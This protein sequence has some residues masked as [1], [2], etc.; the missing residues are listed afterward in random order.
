MAGL[1]TVFT[2]SPWCANRFAVFIDDIAP[3]TST[4]PPSSGW[5]DPSFTKCIPTQYT[6]PY[7]T[8]SPGIC[9][10]HMQIV[11]HTSEVHNGKM[12]W[13]AACCQRYANTIVALD[14]LITDDTSGFSPLPIDDEYLCTSAITTPMAFLL[15][16]DIATADV[17]TTLPPELWIE[18]DQV[19]VQWEPDDLKLFPASVIPQY[20]LMM[21]ITP[22]P[23]TES[24]AS[25]IA[26]PHLSTARSTSVLWGTPSRPALQSSTS[27]GGS[28]GTH[29]N[30][31]TWQ[32]LSD[33]VFLVF[34][35][36]GTVVAL[37]LLGSKLHHT[38]W[39]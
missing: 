28:Q 36:F 1:T 30:D 15:D 26:T 17:Y 14:T 21:G 7:P 23:S 4:F 31:R 34:V 33:S 35:L 29:T 10:A 25:P 19:T 27:K 32:R 8:F 39:H 37:I 9:P 18:H 38:W 3:G 13:T 24:V 6:T 12:T 11:K 16:P 5:I 20:E 2:P 22:P